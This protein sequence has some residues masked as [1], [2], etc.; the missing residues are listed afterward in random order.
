MEE[1]TGGGRRAFFFNIE[2]AQ[3]GERE[4]TKEADVTVKG[5]GFIITLGILLG[6]LAAQAQQTG[7]MYRIGFLGNSTAALEANLVGP[8]REGLRDL[9]YIEGRN[10]LIEYRWAEGKY[11]RFPALIGELLVRLPLARIDL[12]LQYGL[13]LVVK[14]DRQLFV[15]CA[16]Y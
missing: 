7:N 13:Q 2:E 12:R 4:R 6:S 14:R 16:G 5:I 1:S 3:G 8:F 11:D 10:V 9:G 15:E